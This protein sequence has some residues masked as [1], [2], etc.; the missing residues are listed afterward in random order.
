[1]N[2]TIWLADIL[3]QRENRIL[4]YRDDG[5]VCVCF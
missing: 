1:M 3:F 5:F 2:Q 4:K